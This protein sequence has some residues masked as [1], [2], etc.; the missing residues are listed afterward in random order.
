MSFSVERFKTLLCN[1][2]E[3]AKERGEISGYGVK[4]DAPLHR[5]TAHVYVQGEIGPA[6]NVNYSIADIR[7]EFMNVSLEKHAAAVA[8]HLVEQLRRAA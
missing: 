4:Q 6:V 3:A 1:E 7:V 8:T 2:L 5:T